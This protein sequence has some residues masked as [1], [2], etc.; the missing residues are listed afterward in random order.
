MSEEQRV[1]DRTAVW[2]HAACYWLLAG[3]F[4]WTWWGFHLY[5]AWSRALMTGQ[6]VT[7][8]DVSG[9]V[10]SLGMFG[11]VLSALLMQW[12]SPGLRVPLGLGRTQRWRNLAVAAVVPA[13]AVFV[14]VAV[15]QAVGWGRFTWAGDQPVVVLLTLLPIAIVATLTAAG[16]EYGWRGYMLTRLWPAGRNRATVVVGVAWGL[17]HL[18]IVAS[19]LTYPGLAVVI[20]V[21]VFILCTVLL[22]FWFTRVFMLPGGGFVVAAISHGVL[23]AGSELTSSR[24]LPD[25]APVLSNPFGILV[26]VILF[27]AA[28]TARR[29]HKVS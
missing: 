1:A 24:H 10:V 16:E 3:L 14:A 11:P 18:P 23:N 21:P 13:G 17:W 7:S 19:G 28:R 27:A 29:R 25:V 12:R 20:A 5:P 2:K 15:I 22:S 26:A 4:S 8:A 9:V 6:P